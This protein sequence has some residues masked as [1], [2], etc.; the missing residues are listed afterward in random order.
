MLVDNWFLFNIEGF[1]LL[2]AYF[3]ELNIFLLFLQ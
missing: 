2:E 1:Q 3:H